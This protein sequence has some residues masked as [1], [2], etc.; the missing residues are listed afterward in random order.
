MLMNKT[1]AQMDK[2]FSSESSS[3]IRVLFKELIKVYQEQDYNEEIVEIKSAPNEIPTFE[4]RF[5]KNG[6]DCK[7]YRILLND[8]DIN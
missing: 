4:L 6:I 7:Y 2:I 3:K 1:E 8:N 5:I